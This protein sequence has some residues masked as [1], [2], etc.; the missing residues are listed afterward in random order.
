MDMGERSMWIKKI[1]CREVVE[2]SV[3]HVDSGNAE[4]FAH[5][6]S[7]D[8]TLVRPDGTVLHG[9][10]AIGHNYAARS[11]DRITRHLVTNIVVDVGEDGLART[12]SYVLLWS[13]STDT[14]DS[15]LGRQAHTR[16]LVGEFHDVLR[17]E[18]DGVWR[19]QQR[20]AHFILHME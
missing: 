18:V 2:R 5:L 1:A 14:P 7:E 19:I 6:F 15:M 10:D 9:R 11:L 8:A 12:C 4:A 17:Q 20:K 13:G 16:Q 3:Q